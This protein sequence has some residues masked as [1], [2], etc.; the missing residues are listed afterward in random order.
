MGTGRGWPGACMFLWC[1]L[2]GLEKAGALPWEPALQLQ[3]VLYCFILCAS[4]GRRKD[5]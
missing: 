3:K 4:E 1:L 5:G 2:E